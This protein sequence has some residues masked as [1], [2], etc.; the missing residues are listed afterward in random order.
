MTARAVVAQLEACVQL[1][2]HV[3]PP[4]EQPDEQPVPKGTHLRCGNPDCQSVSVKRLEKNFNELWRIECQVC[5]QVW[6]E[7]MPQESQG[8]H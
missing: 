5:G 1:E 6:A 7:P 4:S 3:A 8:D 2:Q